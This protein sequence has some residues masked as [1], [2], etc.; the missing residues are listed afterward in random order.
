MRSVSLLMVGEFGW[1]LGEIF[2]LRWRRVRGLRRRLFLGLA[3]SGGTG[4]LARMNCFGGGS[5]AMLTNGG[6]T[7]WSSPS[8]P[9]VGRA[10]SEKKAAV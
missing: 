8:G 7:V 4:S 6:Q 10:A 1:L 3:R 2:R 9:D 5:V